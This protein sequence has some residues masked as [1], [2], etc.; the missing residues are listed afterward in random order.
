MSA[1][2][3]LKDHEEME[4]TRPRSGSRTHHKRPLETYGGLTNILIPH[5]TSTSVPQS[6]RE[7]IEHALL[8]SG[9]KAVKVLG[10]TEPDSMIN[11]VKQLHPQKGDKKNSPERS[12]VPTNTQYIDFIE[13]LIENLKK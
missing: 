12:P 3:S 5:N 10:C 8:S 11:A 13:I 7:E 4:S 6:L 1:D 9:T 2:Q